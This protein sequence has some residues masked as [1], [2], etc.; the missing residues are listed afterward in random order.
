MRKLLLFAQ[1]LLSF[2]NNQDLKMKKN[3][4]MKEGPKDRVIIPITLICNQ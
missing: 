1:S 4:K 2:A 3:F